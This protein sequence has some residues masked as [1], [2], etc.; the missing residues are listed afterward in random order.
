MNF[1]VAYYRDVRKKNAGPTIRKIIYIRRIKEKSIFTNRQKTKELP[2]TKV[3]LIIT[4]VYIVVEF[5][6]RYYLIL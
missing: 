2:W 3:H 4:S 1:G 6:L 5:V